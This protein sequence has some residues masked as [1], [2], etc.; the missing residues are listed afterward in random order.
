MWNLGS[1]LMSMMGSIITDGTSTEILGVTPEHPFNLR[2]L[3]WTRADQLQPGDAVATSG[4]RWLVVHAVSSLG[5]R[6]PVFNL[7]IADD[8]N[9]F[10][11]ESEA[12]VHNCV[13]GRDKL[14]RFTSKAGGNTADAARGRLAH[15]NYRD[16]LGP[17][18]RYDEALPS[19]RRPDAVDWHNRVVRELKPDKPEAVS[20][21]WRQV[22]RYRQE[23]EELTGQFWTAYVDTYRP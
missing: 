19:G 7:S 23:L 14:G 4:D 8:H 2:E 6:E 16:A 10:V 18:Y 1:W 13:P 21:G 12:W 3:G 17:A 15:N 9:Y 11:G 22:E 20:R 5:A